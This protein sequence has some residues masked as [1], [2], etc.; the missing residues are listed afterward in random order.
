[1][2][3]GNLEDWVVDRADLEELAVGCIN[4]TVAVDILVVNPL[5]S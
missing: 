2:S 1:M 4:F 5:L 3:E